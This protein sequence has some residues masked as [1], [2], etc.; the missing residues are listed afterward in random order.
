MH[1]RHVAL[2]RGQG[3]VGVDAAVQPGEGDVPDRDAGGGADLAAVGHR[4]RRAWV[5][6]DR[7]A[8]RGRRVCVS[9]VAAASR[10]AAACRERDEAMPSAAGATF[11]PPLCFKSAGVDRS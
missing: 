1:R 11:T 6:E 9:V 5:G 7:R 2:V 8:G 10:A 3:D 4:E